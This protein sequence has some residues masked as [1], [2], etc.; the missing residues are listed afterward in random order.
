MVPLACGGEVAVMEVDELTTQFAADSPAKV[1]SSTSV[2]SVPVRVTEV[3]PVVGPEEG[4]KL[5]TVGA[6]GELAETTTSVILPELY[7][8]SKRLELRTGRETV[9]KVPIR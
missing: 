5:V 9:R 6:G 7:W 3:P 2:K 4:L 8:M 1:T